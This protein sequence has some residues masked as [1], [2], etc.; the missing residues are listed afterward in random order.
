M[1][2]PFPRKAIP[3]PSRGGRYVW[4]ANAERLQRVES[5]QFAPTALGL[6][7]EPAGPPAVEPATAED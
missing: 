1:T 7:P 5:V 3:K 2:L 6:E 4:D